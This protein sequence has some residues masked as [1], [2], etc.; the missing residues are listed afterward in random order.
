MIHS[1]SKK[2]QP[3]LELPSLLPWQEEVHNHSA[4]YKVLS[5]GRRAGKTRLG[6]IEAFINAFNGKNVFWI[7]PTYQQAIFGWNELKILVSKT[8][9]FAKKVYGS[10]II[11]LRESEKKF[12]FKNG[13][14][15]QAKTGDAPDWLRGV[16]LDLAIL[17]ECSFMKES[18]WTDAIYPALA[19]RQGKALF[20]STPR[21]KNWFYKLYEKGKSDDYK[22]WHSW[23][24]P[25]S[26]NPLISP[27]IMEESKR[28]LPIEKFRQ[29]FEGEF[30]DSGFTVFK[31]F[32]NCL[33]YPIQYEA[34][35][36]HKYII[37]ID[38]GKQSDYTVFSVLDT[39]MEV[40]ALVW[41]E[42]MNIAAYHIQVGKLEEICSK[43]KPYKIIA[44]RNS[45]GEV[46]IEN[47]KNLGYPIEGFTT[48][49]SSKQ[50][51]IQRLKVAFETQSISIINNLQLL[52][53]LEIYEEIT[54]P[55]GLT[56]YSA[57]QGF[58][59]DCVMSLAIG[60][61]FLNGN[62]TKELV[63]LQPNFRQL[64]GI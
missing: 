60:F 32:H 57:P 8:N 17:D 34:I 33:T 4:R 42:R 18:V 5:I 62:K 55:T 13:G 25:S 1:M 29:E 37:S 38:W 7:A 61:D 3:V 59:D 11:T 49:N 64:I 36:S 31:N 50:R 20:I 30:T 41:L 28:N 10:P 23:K 12:E 19:D 56:T 48:S 52:H 39:S 51:I 6:V 43:F 35:D 24:L 9:Q 40:P 16:G 47:I 45:I 44:E 53:E 2:N 63:K 21:G 27:D 58:N 14:W 46:I 22:D 26:V 15:V 54:T